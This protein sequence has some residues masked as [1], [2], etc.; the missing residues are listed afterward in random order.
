MTGK[1][2]RPQVN[3][4]VS[5]MGTN[6]SVPVIELLVVAVCMLVVFLHMLQLL[7]AMYMLYPTHLAAVPYVEAIRLA[8]VSNLRMGC[9]HSRVAH[10]HW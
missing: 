4:A 5:T 10:Q 1:T 9:V 8:W 7:G 2:W 6:A 3:S